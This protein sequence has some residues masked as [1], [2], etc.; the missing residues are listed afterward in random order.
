MGNGNWETAG[1]EAYVRNTADL[2]K[3]IRYLAGRQAYNNMRT[4]RFDGLPLCH[5]RHVCVCWLDVHAYAGIGRVRESWH[6]PQPQERYI[7]CQ[8]QCT[9]SRLDTGPVPSHYVRIISYQM[10]RSGHAGDFVSLD[11]SAY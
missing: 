1:R 8:D 9:A 7:Y 10:L 6:L 11:S 2:R 4:I 5:T 3:D